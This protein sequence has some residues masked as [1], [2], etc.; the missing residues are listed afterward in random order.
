[1]SR[2]AVLR[3]YVARKRREAA[4]LDACG[5]H[6]RAFVVEDATRS[7]A[8]CSR[9]AGK[10]HGTAAK[11]FRNAIRFPGETSVFIAISAARANDIL[12]RAF[13]VLGKKIG[14]EPQQTSRNGQIYWEFPNG[15]RV[16][17]AGCKNKAE[18]EKFRGDPYVGCV[19]DECDSIRNH[20]QYLVE[21]VLEPA[22]MDLRGWLALTGTPGVTPAGYFHAVTTGSGMKKWATHHWTC[23]ENPF[24]DDP[25][26][27]LREYC[28]KHGLDETSP[29]YQREWLGQ[30]VRDSDA[31]VYQYDP[32]RNGTYQP[33]IDLRNEARYILGVDLGVVDATAIAA[34][35]YFPGNPRLDLIESKSWT[36]LSPSGAYVKLREFLNRYPGA[37]VVA[38]CGGQGKAFAQ[39]WQQRYGLYVEP[40]VKLDL[41][42]Q[43]AF[44]NGMLRSGELQV[45]L[46]GCSSLVQEWQQ[47]PWNQDRDGHEDSY[48]D[49]ESDAARY[50]ALAAR[51]NYKAELVPPAPG[52]P[53][54]EAERRAKRLEEAIAQAGKR[55]R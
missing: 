51:P 14:W 18:A 36:G 16:W 35:G 30:W 54:F 53:E 38:D 21:D 34:L 28:E 39:E 48:P 15:H 50:A 9:R 24:L 33:W 3:E 2:E 17:V 55:G 27:W 7:A 13:R 49:H 8:Q 43:V 6:Q 37:R 45:H 1:M 5:P 40:A 10:S 52:S 47:L 46:P 25:A 22:L 12:A 20:L 29:T 23:L 4:V 31:L 44:M 42:G 11:F 32:D 26:G 41:V 19:V